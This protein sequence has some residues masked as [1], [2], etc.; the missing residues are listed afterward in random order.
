MPTWKSAVTAF[1]AGG[2]EAIRKLVPSRVR[3][4]TRLLSVLV[5]D[6]GHPDEQQTCDLPAGSIGVVANPHPQ[7]PSLLIVFPLQNTTQ[8]VSLAQLMRNG[9]FR[10]VVINEATFRAHFEVETA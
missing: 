8:V 5:F 6:P 7:Q 10:T 4:K 2:T 1:P 9:Q 3:T